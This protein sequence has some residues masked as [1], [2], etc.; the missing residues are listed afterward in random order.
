MLNRGIP[1]KAEYCC[2]EGSAYPTFSVSQLF[3]FQLLLYS[4]FWLIKKTVL[5]DL[6]AT[7][8]EE[9]EMTVDKETPLMGFTTYHSEC[10]S[11]PSS[12]HPSGCPYQGCGEAGGE[13]RS[14]TWTGLKSYTGQT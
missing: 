9:M 7:F 13:R 8:F 5:H 2:I 12:V 11:F 1:K 4:I 10:Y 14:T 3:K 6:E